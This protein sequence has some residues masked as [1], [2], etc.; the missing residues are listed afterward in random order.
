MME[1]CFCRSSGNLETDA[2]EES[3]SDRDGEDRCICRQF[4]RFSR[5]NRECLPNGIFFQL[6]RLETKREDRMEGSLEK[7]GSL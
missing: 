2:G 5:E 6:R 1:Q 4:Y 3:S 7:I